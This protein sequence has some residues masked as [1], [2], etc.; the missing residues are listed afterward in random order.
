MTGKGS[1]V[2]SIDIT[3]QDLQIVSLLQRDGR[4]PLAAIAERIGAST[5]AV[6]ERY[7]RLTRS[8]IMTVTAV[9][10]PLA[11]GSYCQA[12]VGLRVNGSRDETLAMLKAMPEVT[13]VVC[14]LG[15][16]DIIAEAVALGNAAM[17][18][19]LKHDLRR[20]PGL[21]RVQV[22]SCSRLVLD[23]HNVSVVNRLLAA[24]GRTGFMTKGEANVG[25]SAEP[26][27]LDPALAQTF[28]ALQSDGRA[29]Y[30]DVGERLGVTHT[31]IRGRVRRLEDAGLMRI[32]ATVSPMR[33]GRFRQAFV[34]LALRPP[35]ELDEMRLLSTDEVTYAMSGVGLGGADYLIEIIADDDEA[36]WRVVDESIRTL[37]GAEQVWWASTVSVEKESYRLRM[38][39]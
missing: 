38:P 14:A 7:R 8:G 24:R 15:D 12:I 36:L 37:P 3:T 39:R 35:Q 23:D 29:S 20:L 18:R 13:Y 10:N 31:A 1:T 33:L 2:E 27:T 30:R 4:M 9:A 32:M 26:M 21:A 22:F 34:G 16:A 5:Y 17:D 28:D 11:F 19:F 25:V 6:T